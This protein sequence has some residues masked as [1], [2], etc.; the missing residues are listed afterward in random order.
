M[1]EGEQAHTPGMKTRVW[2]LVAAAV[3]MLLAGCGSGGD[4]PVG[5]Q[6]ARWSEGNEEWVAEVRPVEPA[7]IGSDD[8]LEAWIEEYQ[9]ADDAFAVLEGVNLESS[10][11][12]IG[13]YPRCQETSRVVIAGEGEVR[14][15]VVEGDPNVNCAWSPYTIDVWEVPL[16]ETG[17]EVPVLVE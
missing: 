17:G 15:E 9:P 5:E 1:H 14:F 10:F 4:D 16:A 7:V 12:V 6:I 11:L 13:A 2:G 3:L 8:E